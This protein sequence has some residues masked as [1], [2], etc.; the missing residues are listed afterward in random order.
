MH[1]SKNDPDVGI[2][3]LLRSIQVSLLR[4]VT[5][6]IHCVGKTDVSEDHLRGDLNKILGELEY[7]GTLC[8]EL[9]QGRLALSVSA[10]DGDDGQDDLPF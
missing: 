10:D 3:H 8:E 5:L 9:L 6:F 1:S 7:V 4:R 2:E